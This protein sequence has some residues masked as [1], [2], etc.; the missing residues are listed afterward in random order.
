M[1][2]NGTPEII[3]VHKGRG[4]EQHTEDFFD[5]AWDHLNIKRP[6]KKQ[7]LLP[8]NKP[9]KLSEMLKQAR[10]LANN[11]PFIRVD[12]YI[13]NGHLYFGECTFFAAGGFASFE[14]DKCDDELGKRIDIMCVQKN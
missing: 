11:I 14:P 4:T 8:I 1:C 3:Q 7:S 2:L 12:W 9:S 5:T 10:V 6:D 13:I